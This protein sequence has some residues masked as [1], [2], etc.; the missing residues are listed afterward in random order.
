MEYGGQHKPS[1]LMSINMNMKENDED[2]LKLLREMQNFHIDTYKTLT[3]SIFIEGNSPFIY[4]HTNLTNRPLK[5]LLDTGASLSIIN[6]DSI[7]IEPNL[8]DLKLHLYGIGGK[9]RGIETLGIIDAEIKINGCKIKASLHVIEADTLNLAD[10]ILGFDFLQLYKAKYD[11][12]NN[13]V[14]FKLQEIEEENLMR[15]NENEN[16]KKSVMQMKI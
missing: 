7:G 12:E 16:E 9:E 13:I 4:L 6:R 15:E 14:E 5:M 1:Q 2:K 10:G 8:R 3:E 11:M